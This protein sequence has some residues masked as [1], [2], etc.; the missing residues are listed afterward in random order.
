MPSKGC[1]MWHAKLPVDVPASEKESKLHQKITSSQSWTFYWWNASSI[2]IQVRPS[3][4]CL[5]L[6]ETNFSDC[7]YLCSQNY[8][9]SSFANQSPTFFRTKGKPWSLQNRKFPA[10]WFVCKQKQEKSWRRFR[11]VVADSK[12]ERNKFRR[13]RR[14]DRKHIKK[15]AALRARHYEV[16]KRRQQRKRIN[17]LVENT[18][19]ETDEVPD[20]K[21]SNTEEFNKKSKSMWTYK[22]E[23]RRRKRKQM[24]REPR[25]NTR[26]KDQYLDPLL[27]KVLFETDGFMNV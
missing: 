4:L 16:W 23:F 7:K 14:R 21:E 19:M 27:W 3:P 15:M 1:L 11:F 17:K 22:R 18:D 20:I 13:L 6:K 25:D 8:N 5:K 24:T 9:T 26:K 12:K 2:L 10:I